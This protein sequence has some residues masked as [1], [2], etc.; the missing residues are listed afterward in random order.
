MRSIHYLLLSAFLLMGCGA[1]SKLPLATESAVSVDMDLAGTSGDRVLV[2]VDPGA[3]AQDQ[4]RFFIPETVPGTYS[5]NDYGQFIEELAALDYDGKPMAVTQVD[6]NTWLIQGAARLDRITYYVNDTFDTEDTGT[7]DVFSPAG[8][9]IL[10][11][12]HFLLNLH[13]FVGYFEGLSER[14]YEITLRTPGDLAPYTSLAPVSAPAGSYKFLANR[15]FEVI[16]NPIQVTAQPAATI[17]LDDIAVTLS[18][19]SPTGRY[20]AEDLKSAVERMMRAQKAFLGD[21]DGTRKYTILLYLSTMEEDAG[22]FG[23]LEHHTSTVVVLPELMDAQE[24]E[25]S[26]TDVVSHEFFHI[27]TPL[28]LHSEEIHYFDYN[29]PKMS[30]HL[31]MYEGA[32]EYFANLFQIRQGLIDEADFYRRIA[33]KIEYSQAYDDRMS[34]TEMSRNVLEEPYASN[35]PNVYE[36]GALINMALDIR[37]RELSGGSMGVLDLMKNLSEK[38]DRDTPFRDPELIDQIV[39]LTYPEIREFFQAHVQG[40]TPIDYA[41]YLGKVGVT[42]EAREVPCSFFLNGQVPFIDADPRDG[43]IFIRE[44]IYLNSS[45][46]ALGLEGGD[47]LQRLNGREVNLETIGELLAETFSWGPETPV[48]MEVERDGA[49]IALEGVAGN[50]VVRQEGVAPLPDATPQQVRLREAWLKG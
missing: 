5:I 47:I 3:F 26:I 22:G 6:E 39:G 10:E 44:G 42:L 40:T 7:H 31:W 24:L 45:M 20:R 11:D 18:V 23:A 35:Y 13:S 48:T 38:Y 27:L 28:N 17:D 33:S 50:P 46:E 8:T 1:G 2:T 14:P 32:T 12:S 41:S 37:L 49:A 36:K 9:N 15:Y 25:A 29:D 16:D 19:H 21:V 43:S 30:Q 34:F 4:V